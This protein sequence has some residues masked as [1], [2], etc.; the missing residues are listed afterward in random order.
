MLECAKV[1]III[2]AG[3]QAQIILFWADIY[4]FIEFFPRELSCTLTFLIQGVAFKI[5]T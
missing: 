5:L 4:L 3:T 1:M 2:Y